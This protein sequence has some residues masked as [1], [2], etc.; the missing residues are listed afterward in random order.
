[1]VFSRASLYSL[2]IYVYP[3]STIHII[4]SYNSIS[5]SPKFDT[6]TVVRL[7]M[8]TFVLMAAGCCT[9]FGIIVFGRCRRTSDRC[10]GVWNFWGLQL[11]RVFFGNLGLQVHRGWPR[12]TIVE[13]V[14]LI[15]FFWGVF[16]WLHG[17]YSVK[18]RKVTFSLEGGE[19]RSS[20]PMVSSWVLGLT[21]GFPNCVDPDLS[22]CI[23]WRS[24]A[25]VLPYTRNSPFE[26]KSWELNM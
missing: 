19:V 4:C 12:V 25:L 5:K 10:I 21:S 6:L 24:L 9:A 18:P 8:N 22:T 23:T 15:V 26:E 3:L 13:G 1:M 7:L 11:S 2:D 14:W 20:T 17:G 16:F